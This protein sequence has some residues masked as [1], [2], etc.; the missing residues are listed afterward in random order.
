MNKRLV[1]GLVALVIA[2]SAIVFLRPAPGSQSTLQL[3]NRSYSV[4]ML[5]TEAAREKGLSGTDSLA[6]D[7]A[8]VFVFPHDSRW[9]IWMKGMKYPID[10]VWLD[11]RSKVVHMVEGAQ[12]ASY[13]KTTFVPPT[14]A[15]Y[16]IELTSGTIKATGISKGSLVALPP[17]M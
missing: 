13:P 4:T 9:G 15:R 5:R 14:K 1:F 6:A 12:P 10:I 7:H 2:T 17:G 3:G 16:V 11:S 8:M